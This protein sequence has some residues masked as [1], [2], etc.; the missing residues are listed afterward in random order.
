MR[1]PLSSTRALSS[2]CFTPSI[3]DWVPLYILWLRAFFYDAREI[4]T[5]FIERIGL[6]YRFSPF[7]GEVH[8]QRL[9]PHQC[10]EFSDPF[11]FGIREKTIM[12]ILNDFFINADRRNH[13]RDPGCHVFKCFKTAFC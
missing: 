5:S 2:I 7:F 13:G 8:P 4:V 1:Y 12:A 11:L 6:F 10:G 3:M 9:V